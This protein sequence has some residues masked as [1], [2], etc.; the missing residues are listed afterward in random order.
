M[1]CRVIDVIQVRIIHRLTQKCICWSGRPWLWRVIILNSSY[2]TLALWPW[3]DLLAS[4]TIFLF[5]CLFFHGNTGTHTIRWLYRIRE[6]VCACLIAS[7]PFP[8]SFPTLLHHVSG[9]GFKKRMTKKHPLP[10]QGSRS[11]CSWESGPR[12][13]LCLGLTTMW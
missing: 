5:I 11:N 8:K 10:S 1:R 9:V 6:I 3:A 13:T 4:L 12:W 7:I 2:H